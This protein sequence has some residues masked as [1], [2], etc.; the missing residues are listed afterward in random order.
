MLKKDNW[1]LGI[2]LGILAP[3]ITYGII[4]LILKLI[5]E[6]VANIRYLRESTVQLLAIASNLPIFRYYLVKLKYDKTGRGVLMV[7]FVLT[8]VFFILNM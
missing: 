2:A 3:A 1:I 7:T 5:G 4:T 8:I 6:P